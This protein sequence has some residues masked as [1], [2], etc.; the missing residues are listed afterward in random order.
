MPLAADRLRERGFNQ[1]WEVARRVARPLGRPARA[2]LLLRW[3]TTPHQIGLD[4]DQ[5]L[6]NLRGAFMPAPTARALLSG[7][8][9]A[10]VDDVMTTGASAREAC[11]ALRE[12]GV[13]DISL[14]LLAR[15]PPQR[16]RA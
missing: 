16:A 4:H 10:L 13:A 9:V 8:H 5:R 14:W 7:R 12:A 11:L 15:T 1:A 6:A 2:D 3:R